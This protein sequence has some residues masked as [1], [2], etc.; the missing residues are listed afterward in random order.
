VF[1]LYLNIEYV[2]YN[3]LFADIFS[4]LSFAELGI[5]SVI[6]YNLYREVALN[7]EEEIAKLMLIYKYIYR[8]IGC[9][10]AIIGF[11]IFFLL[12]YIIVDNVSDW[13]FVRLIYAIQLIGVISGYFF[14][15]KRSLYI[16]NQKEFVCVKIDTISNIIGQ[17]LRI[18]V[19][20][21]FKNF[22]F[23]LIINVL[24]NL[25]TN[26]IIAK[27][28]DNTYFFAKHAKLE[29]EDLTKRNFFG[30]VKNFMVHKISYIVYSG[31][32]NI[33]I[34]I[35]LGINTVGFF[36]NYT[37]I[38][39]QVW[40]LIRKVLN[41]M[42]PSIGNLISCESN[43]DRTKELFNA[44]ELASFILATFIST[45]FLVLFQPFIRLW[46]GQEY[47]LSMMVVILLVLN[48]YLQCVQEI[49]SY[50]RNAFGQYD[51]DRKYMIIA[52]ITNL[53]LS[54]LFGIR[55]GL[56]GILIGTNIGLVIIWFGRIKFI[57]N[58][59]FKMAYKKYIV[60][61]MAWIVLAA[62]ECAFIYFATIFIQETI[63][64]LILKL[65]ICISVPNLMNIL[66][67]YKSNDFKLIVRYF[68]QIKSIKK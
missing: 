60:K 2:G 14:A 48:I 46:I 54:I 38:K 61:H 40:I 34:S 29:K 19:L 59:Y 37:L 23:Y 63:T 22:I 68:R 28:C 25:M 42:Q 16:A 64:G 55:F 51:K 52:A 49:L 27:K 58:M 12:E 44:L 11:V 8:I 24:Q 35:I 3:G 26:L 62:T 15:Y 41:P 21:A 66:F 32:D 17:I 5:G 4:I 53:F 45:C 56:T 57:Y 43:L 13:S 65:L 30:D 31:V 10:V 7:N 47:L 33:V 1:L 20:I 6:L 9:V 67:F 18:L 39:N 36:S 50:F